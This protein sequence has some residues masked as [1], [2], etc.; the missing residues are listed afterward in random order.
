MISNKTLNNKK[1][2]TPGPSC[3]SKENLMIKPCFGRGDNE[4]ESI[5]KK[6]ENILSKMTGEK[7]II[8][9]QGS[10]SLALEIAAYNFLKGKILVIVSGY[11]SKRLY[12]IIKNTMKY[13]NNI[14]EIRK[15]SIDKIKNL[16]NK[17]F[18][19]VVGC[20]VETARA[21]L[22]EIKEFKNIAK[23]FHA[24]LM[25]DATGSIGLEKNHELA[26][27]MAFNS[28]KGLFG[29]TGAAFIAYSKKL[30]T[31]KSNMFYLK[32]KTHQQKMI[33]GPYHVI[34]SLLPILEKYDRYR[35]SVIV[36]KKIAMERFKKHLIYQKEHQPLL[37]TA[38]NKKIVAKSKNVVLYHPREK[39]KANSVFCH[40]GEYYLGYKAKGKILNY[41]KIL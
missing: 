22:I 8:S 23:M 11:Y 37:C 26:D 40:L 7:E 31:N 35:Y 34:Q 13:F 17:K 9:L 25:I 38:I 28:C 21:Y 2:F 5:Y 6:V 36:N 4:Y 16:K 27:L 15:T 10:A 33:T 29:L 14:V 19:W 1:M 41:L 3:L 24:K 32:I 39:S 30:K 12:T 18:D 20:P